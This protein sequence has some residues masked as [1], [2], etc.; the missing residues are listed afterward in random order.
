[1]DATAWNVEANFVRHAAI[2]GRSFGIDY[3]L[4]QRAGA[5]VVCVGDNEDIREGRK[6]P[7]KFRRLVRC[8]VGGRRGDDFAGRGGAQTYCIEGHVAAAVGS[9]V[10][11]P[12]EP[13]ALAEATRVSGASR[14]KLDA[15]GPARCAIERAV[16]RSICGTDVGRGDNRVVL[17]AIDAAVDIIQVVG[18]HLECVFRTACEFDA[19]LAVCKDG[20][21]CE[22]ATRA[23]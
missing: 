1:M 9:H 8:Q 15:K 3:G 18:R 13:L 19:E 6:R 22:S 12:K 10:N 20:V 4:P 23:T 7:G 21:A 14:E 2:I 17:Q 16:D 11:G 5:A